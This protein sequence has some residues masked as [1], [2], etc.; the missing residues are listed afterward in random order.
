ML[1]EVMT[2]F[3]IKNKDLRLHST[4]DWIPRITMFLIFPWSLFIL[5]VSSL[6]AGSALNSELLH[7]KIKN[8]WPLKVRASLLVKFP[9]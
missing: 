4:R 8:S 6:P 9:F 2:V 1:D 7:S 3:L 5:F